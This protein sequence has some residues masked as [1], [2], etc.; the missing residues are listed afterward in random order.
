MD[1]CKHALLLL[2]IIGIKTLQR[3]CS[4]A[5]TLRSRSLIQYGGAA[6]AA[7]EAPSLGQ[8]VPFR[9]CTP[10]RNHTDALRPFC[11]VPPSASPRARQ[12]LLQAAAGR[13]SSRVQEECK[14]GLSPKDCPSGKSADK[15]M[16]RSRR[17]TG[18][19]ALHSIPWD[20]AGQCCQT[21]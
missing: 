4:A 1:A 12:F 11:F 3:P 10:P 14:E 13:A 15:H 21:F 20:E 19:Y 6:F 16:S 18:T 9:E 5:Q 2:A 8:N 17:G 7:E